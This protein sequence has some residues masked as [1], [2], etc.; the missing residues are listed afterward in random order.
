MI[1]DCHSLIRIFMAINARDLGKGL[2]NHQH[3]FPAARDYA[4]PI[5]A[6]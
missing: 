1:V 5:D 4:N 2:Q 3:G 6:S